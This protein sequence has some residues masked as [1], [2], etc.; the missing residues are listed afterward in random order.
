MGYLFADFI[1]AKYHWFKDSYCSPSTPIIGKFMIQKSRIH[2]I[3]PR[4]ILEVSDA[5][6]LSESTFWTSLWTIPL[7][8]IFRKFRIFFATL[9]SFI[10]INDVSHKYAHMDDLERPLWATILQKF[11][12]FQSYEEHHLHHIEP[13]D[14]NYAP[15]T[16]WI[17]PILEK[18]NYWRRLEKLIELSIGI[19]A[20]N[21][22]DKYVEDLS[23]PSGIRFVK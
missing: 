12:L 9:F 22:V 7:V 16:P 20:R 6:I 14:S 18:I 5:K 19:K 10:S 3:K 23:Q 21:N 4:Y 15:I 11:R 17:N 13:H 1:M 2:H 8:F